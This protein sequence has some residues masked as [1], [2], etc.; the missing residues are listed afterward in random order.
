MV[1]NV[2]TALGSFAKDITGSLW[3]GEG[4][5]GEKGKKLLE[6]LGGSV[7]S[8]FVD[9]AK[10]ALDGLITK[11]KELFDSL[12][13]GMIDTFVKPATAAIG[14]FIKDTIG[15]LIGGKGFGGL[16]DSIKGIGSAIGGIFGK[17]GGGGGIDMGDILGIGGGGGGGGGGG[18]GNILGKFA[19]GPWGAVASFAGDL[20][21]FVGSMRQEGTLNAIEKEVRYSQIH[22]SHI[23]AN[24][25]DFFHRDWWAGYQNV[26]DIRT[27]IVES[28][29]PQLA[30]TAQKVDFFKQLAENDFKPALNGIAANTASIM[31]ATERIAVASERSVTMNLFG[32]DPDIVAARVAQQLRMQGANG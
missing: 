19:G 3:E 24:T 23:L 30:R 31:A 27:A 29:E 6:S 21:S 15:D 10:G 32:T 28:M 25:N 2:G 8:L 26:A 9:P 7:K 14:D 18:W 13:K 22:L 17:G 16:L 1:T 5:F 12:I 20:L 4:S 11:G